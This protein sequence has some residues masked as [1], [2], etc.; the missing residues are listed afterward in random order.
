MASRGKRI[1]ALGTD[2]LEATLHEALEAYDAGW[3]PHMFIPEARRD[4]MERVRAALAP[5]QEAPEWTI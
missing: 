3:E 4:R 1:R 2:D 5:Q